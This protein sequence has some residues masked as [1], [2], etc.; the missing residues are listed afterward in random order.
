MAFWSRYADSYSASQQVNWMPVTEQLLTIGYGAQQHSRSK[1]VVWPTVRVSVLVVMG[2]IQSG[3]APEHRL[4]PSSSIDW[5]V[6]L[7]GAAHD[8]HPAAKLHQMNL[9]D[10][11]LSSA[12]KTPCPCHHTA[13]TGDHLLRLGP[14]VS[15]L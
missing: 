11:S 8:P 1:T 10:R 7:V 12:F 5:T 2:Q 6:L 14:R 13:F 4:G 3:D 15:S 9:L